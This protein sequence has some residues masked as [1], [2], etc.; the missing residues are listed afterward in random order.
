MAMATVTEGTEGTLRE[1]AIRVL[2]LDDDPDDRALARLVLQHEMPH[3]EVEEVADAL[4]FAQAC[5][6]RNFHLVVLE[7]RLQWTEGLAVLSALKE[8]WPE[9]P[10]IMFTRFGNEDIGVR[11]VRLGADGYLVKRPA[12]FLRL[13]LTVRSSLEQARSRPRPPRRAS[14]LESLLSRARMGVFSATPEGR[15]LNASPAMLEILGANTLEE[16]AKLDLSPLVVGEGEDA[17]AVSEPGEA[18]SAREVELRRRDGRPIRLQVIRSLLRDGEGRQRVDGLVEDVTERRSAEEEEARRS[19][20]L[21]RANEDLQQFALIASHELQEPA[22]MVEKYTQILREDYRG[23]LDSEADE[24]IDLVAAS[25]RKLQSLIDDLLAF[26]RLES[27]E[28]PLERV[29]AGSLLDRALANLDAAIEESG[30]AITCSALP[31]IEA[32]PSQIVQ[33]FQNLIANAIKFRND[34]PPRVHVSASRSQGEW[35]FAVRDNGIGIDPRQAESIFTLFRRLRPD[36]P[37]TG[38][39]LA[40]CKKIV[41]RHGGRIWVTSQPGQGSTFHFTLPAA[42]GA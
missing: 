2:L 11:A 32:N 37:G 3:L 41:E 20:Q 4:A 12:N 31:V 27:R 39:G 14:R 34:D 33:L 15:L 13:P 10:V 23:R 40:L 36:I 24:L 6:R 35:T 30:A 1:S 26:S 18:A 16:A 22:R 25:T 5:G 42:S 38:V 17:P 21:R 8:D 19:A 9:L 7:Q 29:E 28:R